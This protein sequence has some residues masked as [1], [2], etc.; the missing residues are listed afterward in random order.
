MDHPDENIFIPPHV[1]GERMVN[2][3]SD[4]KRKKYSDQPFTRELMITAAGYHPHAKDHHCIR[5]RGSRGFV[6]LYCIDG[7]GWAKYEDQNITITSNQGVFLRPGRAHEYGA[8]KISPWSY[9][10]IHYE[11]TLADDYTRLIL[12]NSESGTY[13][14]KET[15]EYLRAFLMILENLEKGWEYPQ[16]IMASAYLHKMLSYIYIKKIDSADAMRFTS[17]KTR[18][19]AVA[20]MI[21]ESPHS[22]ISVLELARAANLSTSRFNEVFKSVIGV[23]PKQYALQMKIEKSKELLVRTEL[24]IYEVSERVGFVDSHYFTRL[25]TRK[26]GMAPSEF[27]NKYGDKGSY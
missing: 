22:Q 24:C 4:Y 11:G 19:Q 26:T 3:L 10:Y 18:V 17:A 16:M 12:D 21:E 14:I 13:W 27:R 5:P 8:S 7:V 2:D 15:E 1:P 25:F 6:F 23:S 9:Y 20:D